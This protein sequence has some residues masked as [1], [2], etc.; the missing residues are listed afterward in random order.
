M[1]MNY[2]QILEFSVA[3]ELV[4]I[5]A[6]IF[7]SHHRDDDFDAALEALFAT[8]LEIVS[9]KQLKPLHEVYR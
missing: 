4:A 5:A 6:D 1:H 8:C 3:T 2:K 9:K 7:E